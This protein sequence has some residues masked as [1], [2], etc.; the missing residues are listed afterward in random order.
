MVCSSKVVKTVSIP[1]L[2]LKSSLKRVCCTE[3]ITL[4]IEGNALI[5]IRVYKSSTA[6]SQNYK[7]YANNG[8]A[9]RFRK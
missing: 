4:L 1:W 5:R 9:C 6:G 8:Y 7:T 3:I 2:L